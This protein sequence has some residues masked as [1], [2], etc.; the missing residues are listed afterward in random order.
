M[1]RPCRLRETDTVIELLQLLELMCAG[2]YDAMQHSLR[3]QEG[4]RVRV[5]SFRGRSV[6]AVPVEVAGVCAQTQVDVLALL[7]ELASSYANL[8][9]HRLHRGFLV[10]EIE[11]EEAILE[12]EK[13]LRRE[14]ND[15]K[16]IIHVRPSGRGLT[17]DF[18][19]LSATFALLHGGDVVVVC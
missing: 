13:E 9:Q 19:T 1:L 15:V 3:F 12:I 5:W 10:Q 17:D 16:V 8:I 2:G 4:Q 14:V 7:V 11:R 18:E 6:K